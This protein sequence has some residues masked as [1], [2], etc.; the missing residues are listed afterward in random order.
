MSK[1]ESRP[2]CSFFQIGAC[3]KGHTCKFSHAPS[4]PASVAICQSHLK[5]ECTSG[6]KC[7][8]VHEVQDQPSNFLSKTPGSPSV[9]ASRKNSL[10]STYLPDIQSQVPSTKKEIPCAFFA[11][12]T[13]NKGDTCKYS[14]TRTN[15][16]ATSPPLLSALSTP[17]LHQIPEDLSQPS[18]SS[19]TSSD[20]DATLNEPESRGLLLH[21]PD[22]STTEQSPS[23]ETSQGS[24][25]DGDLDKNDLATHLSHSGEEHS[26]ESNSPRENTSPTTDVPTQESPIT[27]EPSEKH[28]VYP[29]PLTVNWAGWAPPYVDPN[30]QNSHLPPPVMNP[31]MQYMHP[32]Y[33]HPYPMQMVLPPPPTISSVPS[34]FTESQPLCQYLT[35]LGGCPLG[36]RCMFRHTL[37]PEEFEAA[38]GK[39]N[40]V[41][42]P[43]SGTTESSQP[44]EINQRKLPTCIFFVKGECNKGDLCPFDHGDSSAPQKCLF[45]G[46]G[47][48]RNGKACPYL[49]EDG[50]EKRSWRESVSAPQAARKTFPCKYF[51]EGNCRK[52][53][54]CTFAHDAPVQGT[55]DST[56][57]SGGDGWDTPGSFN[58]SSWNAK[59]TTAN[60]WNDSTE[61]G[62]WGNQKTEGWSN[63]DDGGSQWGKAWEDSDSRG[64]SGWGNDDQS[65]K[66]GA[67]G[68]T[69]DFDKSDRNRGKNKSW[70]N[71][72]GVGEEKGKE[73]GRD[74]QRRRRGREADNQVEGRENPGERGFNTINS[75]RGSHNSTSSPNPRNVWSSPRD[76]RSWSTPSYT[77]RIASKPNGTSWSTTPQDEI[78]SKNSRSQFEPIPELPK[79]SIEQEYLDATSD[80][81]R[82]DFPA[83]ETSTVVGS[84]SSQAASA[85]P[86][87]RNFTPDIPAQQY[88]D[89]DTRASEDQEDFGTLPADVSP[90]V[91]A[92]PDAPDAQQDSTEADIQQRSLQ[93]EVGD[94]QSGAELENSEPQPTLSSWADDE[95]DKTW[96]PTMWTQ[97]EINEDQG[98]AEDFNRQCL[99]F[100]Q[101]YC[102]YGDSCRYLHIPQDD[103]A[104]E[105][106][107]SMAQNTDSPE[108]ECADTVLEKT[109]RSE[110]SH[111]P[112]SRELELFQCQAVFGIGASC[113]KLCTPS[114]SSTLHFTNLP[115]QASD[116]AIR[117][118]VEPFGNIDGIHMDYT[119]DSASAR[120]E[121]SS[122][123]EAAEAASQL[124]GT[125]F[126]CTKLSVRLETSA[127]VEYNWQPDNNSRFVR[128]TY[129]TPCRLAWAY[130]NSIS[131]AKAAV[132]EADGKLLNGRKISVSFPERIRK[133]QTHSFPVMVDNLPVSADKT[134]V[135]KFLSQ[136]DAKPP[137]TFHVNVQTYSRTE[138][139]SDEF[140]RVAETYGRIEDIVEVPYE[141]KDSRAT[142][143]IRY[144]EEEAA[145]NAVTHLHNT[146]HDILGK[147]K[148][149]VKHAYFHKH[150]L[151]L[152]RAVP[153]QT[154]LNELK[155]CLE[156]DGCIIQCES[157]EDEFH[158]ILCCPPDP[159]VF[160][161][162]KSKLAPLMQGKILLNDVGEPLWDDY[163]DHPSS[164]KHLE[165]LNDKNKFIL[166]DFW[167]HYVLVLGDLESARQSLLKLLKSVGE[168]QFTID[169]SEDGFLAGLLNGGLRELENTGIGPNK[170]ELDL[171]RKSLLVRGP[172]DLS[173]TIDQKVNEFRQTTVNDETACTICSLSATDPITLQC[174]H[175]YCKQC[176]LLYFRSMISPKF[177]L[178]R[179]LGVH[180]DDSSC[181]LDIPFHILQSL[182]SE[183]EQGS[184]FEYSFLQFIH[185]NTEQ[186]RLCPSSCPMVYRVGRPGTVLYCSI[187]A[188]WICTHCHVELHEGLSC[189]EYA[190]AIC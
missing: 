58:D 137:N 176:L 44:G 62:S 178:L 101:G 107:V 133:S 13:C 163:F 68:S 11:K 117:E 84:R 50:E 106:S 53:E 149:S 19:S 65:H 152:K 80:P 186:Y 47:K 32:A 129:P 103:L 140:R 124:N 146:T 147:N 100:A 78:T 21:V 33:M 189:A 34:S 90:I 142:T 150:T 139:I 118:L 169:V 29:T 111:V 98:T 74:S 182:L 94:A 18:N 102:P 66:S 87:S 97:E 4:K 8:N 85:T 175:K 113:T 187:C 1:L 83:G 105:D 164:T 180:G 126:Q 166:R 104:P 23:P 3:K 151:P 141:E 37:T 158:V 59:G 110:L 14:H 160:V 121:L 181:D 27:T 71:D 6:D 162:A 136:L 41:Q 132:K 2:L 135:S 38:K 144:A 172:I 75:R 116:E 69:H 108:S 70:S 174:A 138:E 122:Y 15:T 88:Q 12:G 24:Q 31:Y 143:L 128:I 81:N 99:R 57:Y 114:E 30:S 60:Q 42:A 155:T 92:S 89:I 95:D 171:H 112:T 61:G 52:G 188:M 93:V 109:P 157:S 5:G 72:L 165:K 156:Q 49:H 22:H 45:Y 168:Q 79:T 130:Y 82:W 159:R 67:W 48:C 10:S 46:N 25:S 123:E 51:A 134:A 26:A 183:E 115:F 154:E 170:V 9:A 55:S 131:E 39:K 173:L 125:D 17:S 148:I 86:V 96:A 184:L 16:L 76:E 40:K 167:N 190:A 177:R 20:S 73:W 54:I 35:Q 63:D 43:L 64:N 153:I 179:C 161:R 36:A 119:S 145:V 185:S 56:D 28:N 120:A 7:I 77:D 127:P 91:S